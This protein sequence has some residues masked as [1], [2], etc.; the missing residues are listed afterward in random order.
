MVMDTVTGTITIPVLTITAIT[1]TQIVTIIA[2]GTI[3]I[4]AGDRTGEL[5]ANGSQFKPIG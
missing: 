3:I 1:A 4:G 5:K 2:T